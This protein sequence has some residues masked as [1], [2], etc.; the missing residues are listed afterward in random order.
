MNILTSLEKQ[1][2]PLLIFEGFILI[3]IIG[4]IDY[5]T[6]HEFAFSVFY[7]LPIS[8]IAWF[9]N[10]RLGLAASV[11]SAIVW[12]AADITTAQSYSFPLIPI[13]NSF[14]RLA[15]FIIIANLLSSLK[16]TLELAHTDHLT[17]AINSRYFYEILQME[18]NR[19]QRNQCPFTIAYIDIDNFK[20][21]ND[22]LGHTAGDQVLITLV[23]SIRNI[24]RKSDFISRL[25]GDE[26]AVLFPET[27]QETAHIIFSKIR[28]RFMEVMQQ[29]NWPIT[30]SVGVLTC[31]VA[32]HTTDELIRMA[33]ELMYS[34][35]S[36]GKNTVKYSMYAG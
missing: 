22:K 4:F 7:A 23:N 10:R 30:F 21:V 6:G 27:D 11:V 19:S 34:A 8:M 16:S 15:F 17:S 35:K 32:P 26:F 5:L 36:D 29:K 1:S 14:I 12:L 18:I 33:D 31:R 24:I 2:K 20:A 28:S 9:T 3:G 13:W 25:G